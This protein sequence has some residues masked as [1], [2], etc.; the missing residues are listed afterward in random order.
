MRYTVFAQ[1]PESPPLPVVRMA[2]M[3]KEVRMV[4]K[5]RESSGMGLDSVPPA[6]GGKGYYLNF[7]LNYSPK[8]RGE[9]KERVEE[10]A[11]FMYWFSL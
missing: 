10:C 2:R 3:A 4:R 8:E 6:S 9:R 11:W 7:F 1:L 5:V